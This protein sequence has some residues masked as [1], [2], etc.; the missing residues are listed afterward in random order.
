MD[1]PQQLFNTRSIGAVSEA[2]VSSAPAVA[3]LERQR[4]GQKKNKNLTKNIKIQK[5]TI[6]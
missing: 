1:L 2:A 6:F 4:L 3:E 5:I